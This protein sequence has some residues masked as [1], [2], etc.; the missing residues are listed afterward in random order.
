MR[1]HLGEAHH[2]PNNKNRPADAPCKGASVGG[3]KVPP[4]LLG[5]KYKGIN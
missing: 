1:A 4:D 2:L 3:L 5:Y